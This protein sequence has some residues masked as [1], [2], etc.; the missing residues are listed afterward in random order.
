ME[1]ES[2]N[3]KWERKGKKRERMGMEGTR[4]EMRNER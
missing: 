2:R 1:R 3:R 4:E